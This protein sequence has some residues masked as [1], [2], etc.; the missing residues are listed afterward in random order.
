MN[1][2]GSVG[3][4]CPCGTGSTGSEKGLSHPS[5]PCSQDSRAG[6]RV[7]GS[8]LARLVIFLS[9]CLRGRISRLAN[10]MSSFHCCLQGKGCQRDGHKAERRNYPHSLRHQNFLVNFL[11]EFYLVASKSLWGWEGEERGVRSE[12]LL[13]CCSSSRVPQTEASQQPGC[14]ELSPAWLQRDGEGVGER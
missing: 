1:A 13:S 14:P 9:Q 3:E 6:E 4:V 7:L 2:C 11:S 10:L 5:C 8:A 12:G